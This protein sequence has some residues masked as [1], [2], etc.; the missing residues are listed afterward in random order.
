MSPPSALAYWVSCNTSLITIVWANIDIDATDSA[1]KRMSINYP[2]LQPSTPIVANQAPVRSSV[3]SFKISP[4]LRT[5]RSSGSFEVRTAAVK[6]IQ[7]ASSALLPQVQTARNL[8]QASSAYSLSSPRGPASIHRA[9]SLKHVGTYKNGSPMQRNLTIA[10]SSKVTPRK[11]QIEDIPD[12]PTKIKV[13]ASVS[14]PKLVLDMAINHGGDKNDGIVDPDIVLKMIA[15]SEENL[16][17][18]D[19]FDPALVSA[20]AK[21]G[22]LGKKSFTIFEDAFD[23]S[24]K[25]SPARSDGGRR[26]VKLGVGATVRFSTDA[27]DVIMGSG[28][29]LVHLFQMKSLLLT[30][31]HRAHSSNRSVS[32]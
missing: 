2:P 27:R 31:N 28:P 18:N 24:P 32:R 1:A 12:S 10:S 25:D 5:I 20:V 17:K 16:K 6:Q 30:D 11:V 22:D 26:F 4:S 19:V 14:S 8:R 21:Q 3:G 9:A 29:K 13:Q 15:K 7:M 23:K